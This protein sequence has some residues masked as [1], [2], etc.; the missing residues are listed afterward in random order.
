MNRNEYGAKKIKKWFWKRLFQDDEQYTLWKS[1]GKYKKNIDI[2]VV[3]IEK[4]ICTS[5]FILGKLFRQ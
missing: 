4:R 1:N 3:A 2:I 5:P